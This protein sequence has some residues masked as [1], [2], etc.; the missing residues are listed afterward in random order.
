MNIFKLENSRLTEGHY[1]RKTPE[2]KFCFGAWGVYWC[3][4]THF[5]SWLV[6]STSQDIAAGRSCC[7]EFTIFWG[8]KKSRWIVNIFKPAA[9]KIHAISAVWSWDTEI[10]NNWFRIQPQ[11]KYSHKPPPPCVNGLNQS[12]MDWTRPVSLEHSSNSFL[13]SDSEFR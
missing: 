6:L 3:F 4:F 9:H 1:G 11:A 10:K 7:D 13:D 8:G 5:I 2:A 12:L